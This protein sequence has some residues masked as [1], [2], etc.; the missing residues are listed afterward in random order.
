[1]KNGVEEPDGGIRR[2]LLDV[3][4]RQWKRPVTRLKMLLASGLEK[5]R[6]WRGGS[7]GRGAGWNADAGHMK[8]CYPKCYFETMGLGSLLDRLQRR[9][10]TP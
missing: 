9:Q 8:A 5:A 4:W 6:A 2:K 7:N 1:V 3:L 10:C